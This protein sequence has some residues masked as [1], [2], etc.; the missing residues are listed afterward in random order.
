M[1][2]DAQAMSTSSSDLFT[3]LHCAGEDDAAFF[4]MPC[5]KGNPITMWRSDTHTHTRTHTH[6]HTHARTHTPFSVMMKRASGTVFLCCF[7]SFFSICLRVFLVSLAIHL[8][9]SSCGT[10]GTNTPWHKQTHTH[11]QQSCL[12]GSLHWDLCPGQCAM[13][14]SRC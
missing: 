4:V 5:V 3:D 6:T 12:H 8:V 1:L 11:T 7:F 10:P 9:F 14:S 13:I 2:F